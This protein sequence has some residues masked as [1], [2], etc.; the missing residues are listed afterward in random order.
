MNSY[1]HIQV[2][3]LLLIITDARDFSESLLAAN[4]GSIYSFHELH[5]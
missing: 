1:V 2:S 4:V 5:N 3:F